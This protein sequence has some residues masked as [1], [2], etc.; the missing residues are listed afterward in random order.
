M[1]IE[2]L[3][4]PDTVI[5]SWYMSYD[6]HYI[7]LKHMSYDICHPYYKGCSPKSRTTPYSLQATFLTHNCPSLISRM[8]PKNDKHLWVGAVRKVHCE[9]NWLRN[10]G[11]HARPCNHKRSNRINC[12]IAQDIIHRSPTSRANRS[13][14]VTICVL[15]MDVSMS[16]NHYQISVRG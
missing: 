10:F 1:N 3:H 15:I 8:P 14:S 11:V 5:G 7:V 4:K 9:V 6:G 13:T 2:L 16:S 12:C